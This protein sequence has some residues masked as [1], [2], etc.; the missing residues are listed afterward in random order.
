[1]NQTLWL[2]KTYTTIILKNKSR[3]KKIGD[4]CFFSKNH[5]N[6]IYKNQGLFPKE[7]KLAKIRYA[8]GTPAGNSLNQEYPV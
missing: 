2:Y 4:F 8:P 3:Q 7:I 6:K 1:M 5:R